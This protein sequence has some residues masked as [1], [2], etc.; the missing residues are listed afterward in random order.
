MTDQQMGFSFLPQGLESGLEFAC[1]HAGDD[2]VRSDI[3][4]HDASR[5]Y[6]GA[7]ADGDAAQDGAP[8]AD[9]GAPLHGR[10]DDLPVC[11]GLQCAIGIGTA[12]KFVVDEGDVMTDEN[13]VL[14]LHTF[15]NECVARDLY[16]FPDR[17]ILLNLDK[18]P[19]FGVVADRTAVEVYEAEEAHILP[20]PHVACDAAEVGLRH[21]ETGRRVARQGYLAS[22]VHGECRAHA[23]APARTPR[24]S[25][26]SSTSRPR[27][28]IDRDAL[29]SRRTICSPA[30]PPVM[31]S[32]PV[33]MQS[34]KCWSSTLSASETSSCGANISPE[35]YSTM[36]R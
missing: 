7:F 1:G 36:A 30:R 25:G 17:G 33:S 9:G 29:S 14:D 22:H 11:F 4:C 15:A 31:G 5:A 6:H 18:H 26:S 24:P 12:R 32:Q 21:L 13:I 16:V 10:G 2:G 23:V 35:R 20:E 28:F 27:C 3:P 8:G 19:N 34:T